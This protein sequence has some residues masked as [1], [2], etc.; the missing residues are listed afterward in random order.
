MDSENTNGA[1]ISYSEDSHDMTNSLTP[2]TVDCTSNIKTNNPLQSPNAKRRLSDLMSPSELLQDTL[3]FDDVDQALN[4]TSD[5]HSKEI[6]EISENELNKILNFAVEVTTNQSL[7]SLLDLHYQ[8]SRIIKQYSKNYNRTKLP[9][10]LMSELKRYQ[11]ETEINTADLS[12]D[13]NNLRNI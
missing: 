6:V 12:E 8:L 13:L 9:D 4:E 3:D 2:L 1:R 10:E 7:Q 11:E 5:V